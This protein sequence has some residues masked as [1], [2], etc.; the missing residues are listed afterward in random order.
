M[1]RRCECRERGDAKLCVVHRLKR[2]LVGKKPGAKLFDLEARKT[3][4]F[5]KKLA[6]MIKMKNWS[7]WI[8][9][10]IR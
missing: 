1:R 8:W 10:S 3:G 4:R 6:G 2:R 9:R 5:V 7:S